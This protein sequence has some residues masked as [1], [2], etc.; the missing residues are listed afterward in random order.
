M[1]R[2]EAA[3]NARAARA[4]NIPPIEIRFWSKVDRRSDEECWPWMASVRRK[5]EGY[6]AFS[7]GGRHHP[8]H[9]VALELSG[10][11]VPA[12]MVVCHRCDNPRCCNP[13]HLFVGTPQDNDADRVAKGR[14]AR[15]STNGNAKYTDRFVWGVRMLNTRLGL[16]IARIARMFGVNASG[17]Y[18]VINRGWKHVDHEAMFRDYKREWGGKNVPR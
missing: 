4:K 5:D 18:D 15:G 11:I 6:G 17:L 1:N 10:V 9:R 13:S 14:Q 7:I 12:G 3:A 2:A 16:S 8:A